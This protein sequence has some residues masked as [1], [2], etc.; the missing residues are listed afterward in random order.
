MKTHES[1]FSP[2]QLR[3]YVATRGF[4]TELLSKS[5]LTGTHLQK[6]ALAV[7]LSY[8]PASTL[9]PQVIYAITF[10]ARLNGLQVLLTLLAARASD[11][12]SM[13]DLTIHAIQTKLLREKPKSA[14][15]RM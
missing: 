13:C 10:S 9:H 2:P 3:V 12:V 15:M 7:L 6:R 5:L 1:N 8:S 4:Q 11:R 14:R